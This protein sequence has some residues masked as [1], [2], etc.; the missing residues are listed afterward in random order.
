M[1]VVTFNIRCADD[2]NGHSVP[3][4]APRL[5][6]LL[7]AEDPDL[8]GLQEVTPQWLQLLTREFSDDYVILNKFRS[9]DPEDMEAATVLYKKDRFRALDEGHFWLSDTPWVE[10]LG[11]D[12]L[13]H[14]HRICQW[15]RLMEESTGK[16]FTFLNTHFGFGDSYQVESVRLL[17]KTATLL[18]GPVLFTGD[19]NMEPDS[20]GYL[21]M[22]TVYADANPGDL[23]PTYHDYG[24]AA[25]HI[26]YGFLGGLTAE[27]CRLLNRQFEGKY[28]S[29][30][31]GLSIT[32][33][34]P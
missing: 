31:Y 20:P 2:P 13:Y 32:L 33:T 22:T 21:E 4:R 6:S 26:D 12:V 10:S 17:Q 24:K 34:I 9:T 25:Q 8:I 18:G 29:D 7:R 19:F 11:D 28:P 16:T 5:F 27:E 14:C 30:H 1:K 23:R 3:E 15:V